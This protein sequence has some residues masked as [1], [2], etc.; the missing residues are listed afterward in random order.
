MTIIKIIVSTQAF[1]F[2]KGGKYP[3]LTKRGA[4]EVL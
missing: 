1:E 4:G 2:V 3:S